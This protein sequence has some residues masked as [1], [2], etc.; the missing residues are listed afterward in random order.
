MKAREE[1]GINAM[2][3]LE[4]IG[5]P[6]EHLI[7]T[8]NKIIEQIDKEKGVS[9]KRKEIKEPVLMK[10]KIGVMNKE[11]IQKEDFYTT[12]AEIEV[13]VEDIL[14]LVILMFKYMPS[15]IEIIS[16]EFIVLSNTGW[17]DILNELT[18]RLH[19]YDEI[20]R[21]MQVEKNILEKRL[22]ETLENK[23]IKEQIEKETKK[24]KKTQIKKKNKKFK[25]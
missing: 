12:F 21:I 16:P 23:G 17:N 1:K 10:D 2:F 5:K 7:E 3:I 25:K 9:I 22:R 15:H 19:G 6:K 14:Y 20:A 4:I 24:R 18:R 13:E 11:K 8:L